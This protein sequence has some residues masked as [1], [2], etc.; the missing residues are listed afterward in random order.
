[1]FFFLKSP[2]Y[3]KLTSQYGVAEV[4]DSK[5]KKNGQSDDLRIDLV[6]NPDILKT[7]GEKKSK[8]FLVGFAAETDNLE[9]YAKKKLV[10]KNLDLIV[11][12]EVGR[13]DRGFNV[14]N[15]AVIIFSDEHQKLHVPIT[16]KKNIANI[17]MSK[18]ISELG[19]GN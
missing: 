9:E 10:E 5:M 18:I 4:S 13:D 19:I 15:N 17:L 14:D 16:S 6:E 1:M 3:E 12:N 2:L 11:A 8:Q 7:M